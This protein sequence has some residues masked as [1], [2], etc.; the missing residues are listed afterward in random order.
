MKTV[1]FTLLAAA[2][3]ATMGLTAV[4][5]SLSKT[6]YQAEKDKIAATYKTERAA[7]NSDKGNTKDICVEMAKGKEKVDLANLQE[8]YTPTD[9]T[10][11]NARMAKADADYAVAKERCDDQSG[12][13]KASCRK[14]AKAVH[15]TAKSEA[16]AL[17]K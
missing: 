4:A 11:Y 2:L 15:N 12:D 17:K 16:K 14:E 1:Q 8:R 13:A 5:Q 7:C 10:R 3:G 9:K 6:E